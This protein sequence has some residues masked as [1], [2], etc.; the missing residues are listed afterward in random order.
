MIIKILDTIN[1]LF[2]IVV[3]CKVKNKYNIVLYEFMF[4]YLCFY[5]LLVFNKS[6]FI[7]FVNLILNLKNK[8]FSFFEAIIKLNSNLIKQINQ[9]P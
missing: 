7:N 5:N 8:Y 6:G 1:A 9:Y 4:L 2:F 3:N